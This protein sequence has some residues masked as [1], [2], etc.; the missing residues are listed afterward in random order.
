MYQRGC[1]VEHRNKD[2]WQLP[3]FSC[4]GRYCGQVVSQIVSPT[5]YMVR[6]FLVFS[7]LLA[8]HFLLPSDTIASIEEEVH[9]EL[10]AIRILSLPPYDLDLS[11]KQEERIYACIERTPYWEE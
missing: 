8:S 11:R 3:V 7:P 9:C 5:E 1:L 10:E 2:T 4:D 6:Y